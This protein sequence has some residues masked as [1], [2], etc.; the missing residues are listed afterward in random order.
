MLKL[1]GAVLFAFF[2]AASPV[3]AAFFGTALGT[4]S[5]F[6]GSVQGGVGA[7]AFA[8][9]C[10]KISTASCVLWYGT[11]AGNAASVGKNAFDWSCNAGV[12]T[13]TSVYGTNGVAGV[14]ALAVCI[15]VINV[16]GIYAAIGDA[17]CK[18]TQA[19]A[20]NQLT[21]V[22]NAKGVI[23]A[24]LGNGVNQADFVLACDITVNSDP[25]GAGLA[26]GA[27]RI[28][29][30]GGA[31]TDVFATTNGVDLGFGASGEGWF[32]WAGGPEL[33]ASYTE[34][35]WADEIG[36]IGGFGGTQVTYINGSA[37]TPTATAGS[38]L[39]N[40][41]L[42][43]GGNASGTSFTN[44]QVIYGAMLSGTLSSVDQTAFHNQN[45]VNMGSFP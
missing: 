4:G 27:N 33:P 36:V 21:L 24:F 45:I 43:L 3:L 5:G 44:A 30:I 14:A 19:T 2:V 39:S 35:T 42:G 31:F 17:S 18:L 38:T 37:V 40:G 9:A 11:V 28:T 1:A 32:N 20:L 41:S 13:G 23:P 26:I 7:P 29:T 25:G 10:D 8:G 34:N 12:N 16:T 6:F 15:G 22:L